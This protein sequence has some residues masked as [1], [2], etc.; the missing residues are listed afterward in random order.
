MERIVSCRK[1]GEMDILLTPQ[2]AV[3]R[4]VGLWP[5]AE[6]ERLELIRQVYTEDAIVYGSKAIFRGWNQIAEWIHGYQESDSPV[7]V[8]RISEIEVTSG[9]ARFE[10]RAWV[11]SSGDS[12]EG[13]EVVHFA[14]DGRIDQLVV[15][16]GL[17]LPPLG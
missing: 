13:A 11:D 9:W 4:E 10:W 12:F 5:A 7:R 1:D 14:P 3:D 6:H 16:Y 15:F 17:R 2:E 8:A